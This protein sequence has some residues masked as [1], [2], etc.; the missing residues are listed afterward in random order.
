[1]NIIDIAFELDD[2]YKLQINFEE[3][4]QGRVLN[5]LVTTY[6]S[7]LYIMRIE[8]GNY[9]GFTP[10]PK[11]SRPRS[12]YLYILYELYSLLIIKVF[13]KG[14]H[15]ASYLYKLII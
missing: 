10:Q 2:T 8:C 12:Y 9:K 14:L 1:M 4:G 15:K 5:F 3:L 6:V 11:G 13:N 7:K